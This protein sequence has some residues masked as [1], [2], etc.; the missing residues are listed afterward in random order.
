VALEPTDLGGALERVRELSR[1]GPQLQGLP[2][3]R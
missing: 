3:Q 1:A 2:A